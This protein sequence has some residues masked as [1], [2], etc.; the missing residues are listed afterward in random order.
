MLAMKKENEQLWIQARGA[1]QAT[2]SGSLVPTLERI[3]GREPGTV[4]AIIES[5]ADFAGWVIGGLLRDLKFDVRHKDS[6]GRIAIAGDSRWEGWGAKLFDPL[7]RAGMKFIQSSER[8]AAEEW[9][10]AGGRAS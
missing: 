2:L 5:A 9:S 8:R 4:P 3:A 1:P 10:R 6:F 7:F